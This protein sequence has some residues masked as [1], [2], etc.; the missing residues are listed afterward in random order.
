MVLGPRFEEIATRVL[1]SPPA[2]PL[3]LVLSSPSSYLPPLWHIARIGNSTKGPYAS[4]RL[5]LTHTHTHF[6][7]PLGTPPQA[8]MPALA[9]ARRTHV[10]APSHVL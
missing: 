10:G 6:V 4:A 2:S 8:Q 3:S 7:V 1:T 9:C 5:P